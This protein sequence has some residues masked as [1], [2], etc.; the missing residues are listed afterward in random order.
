MR[1]TCLAIVKYGKR[2]HDALNVQIR[3]SLVR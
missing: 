3:T 1:I 2:L